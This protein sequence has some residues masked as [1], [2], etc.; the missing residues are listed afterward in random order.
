M[1]KIPLLTQFTLS[2]S[3]KNT[4]TLFQMLKTELRLTIEYFS[5]VINL[6][7]ISKNEFESICIDILTKGYEHFFKIK[8]LLETLH[9]SD[10]SQTHKYK[11]EECFNFAINV[12][13]FINS[14]HEL[15]VDKNEVDI[16]KIES[17]GRF[18]SSADE[19]VNQ[20][21]ELTEAKKE[22]IFYQEINVL[23]SY[24][25][26]YILSISKINQTIKY[27]EM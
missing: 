19:L 10:Q 7:I 3:D 2:L 8:T 9:I 11:Y 24:I 27:I 14:I 6:D 26:Q 15:I 22:L 1:N 13:S 21:N 5:Y 16:R 12:T 18:N 23:V 17:M 4:K 20:Y 25:N